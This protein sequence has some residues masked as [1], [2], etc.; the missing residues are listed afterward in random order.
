MA[1]CTA[2]KEVMFYIFDGA[3]TA[4]I[5]AVKQ[6]AQSQFA[7]FIEFTIISF[8]AVTAADGRTISA[9][10]WII[11]CIYFFSIAD[12]DWVF[13]TLA[14]ATDEVAF[15]DVSTLAAIVLIIVYVYYL[16]A[17]IT[18]GISTLAIPTIPS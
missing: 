4:F 14:G 5:V 3:I 2:V 18:N 16:I 1:A 15:T 11:R 6:F 13:N 17:A 8:I 12:L 10:I 7:V 9:M